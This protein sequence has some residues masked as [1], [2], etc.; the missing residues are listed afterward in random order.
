MTTRLIIPAIM[1]LALTAFALFSFARGAEV[2]PGGS[3][4]PS[5][6]GTGS[7]CIA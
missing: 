2:V 7:A 1:A 4:A 6:T 5:T 3:G